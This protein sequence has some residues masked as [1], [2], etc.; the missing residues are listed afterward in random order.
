LQGAEGNPPYLVSGTQIIGNGLYFI[1]CGEQSLSNLIRN[2]YIEFSDTD[3]LSIDADSKNNVI[4]ENSIRL[5]SQAGILLE[6][7]DN[8]IFGNQISGNGLAGG[9]VAG[10]KIGQG[11]V[12]N[13]IPE[14]WLSLTTARVSKSIPPTTASAATAMPKAI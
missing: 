5:H 12:R 8:Q 1:T 6:G 2:N 10:I 7:T 3:G 14:I 4:R 11:A 9:V 13:I